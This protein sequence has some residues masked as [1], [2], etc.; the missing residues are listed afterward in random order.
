MNLNILF[1]N[2][3][4]SLYDN[5]I[6]KNVYTNL[7]VNIEYVEGNFEVKV[8][9]G[10]RK[11]YK[12]L[13][14]FPINIDSINEKSNFW[15]YKFLIYLGAKKA[16]ILQFEDKIEINIEQKLVSAEFCS[17]VWYQWISYTLQIF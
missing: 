6:N 10:K 11:D 12:I 8:T 4:N 3:I 17:S 5:F 2:Y 14:Y 15:L 13:W 1:W 9:P 7:R 16:E